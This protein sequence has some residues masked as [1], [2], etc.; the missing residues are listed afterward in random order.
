MPSAAQVK[1]SPNPFDLLLLFTDGTRQLLL[2]KEK[3]C[4]GVLRIHVYGS[5]SV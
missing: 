1:T 5:V 4:R 2:Q 3:G